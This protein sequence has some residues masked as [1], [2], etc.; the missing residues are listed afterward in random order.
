VIVLDTHIWYWWTG[1]EHGRLSPALLDRLGDAPRIGVCAISCFEVSLAHRRGRLHLP[2]PLTEWFAEALDRSGVELLALTPGI[3]ARAATLAE[4]HRDPFDRMIIATAI[5][6][7]GQ[8]ASVDNHFA[9]YP[10][11]AGRLLA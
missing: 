3:A 1:G 4:H 9:A 2:L 6:W 7:D 8:L 10:E 11:L 5:E